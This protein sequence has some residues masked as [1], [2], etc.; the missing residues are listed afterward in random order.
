LVRIASSVANTANISVGI[1]DLG[2]I[3]VSGLSTDRQQAKLIYRQ[4][5]IEVYTPFNTAF[6]REIKQL[7]Y[8]TRLWNKQGK[9]W[10]VDISQ[11]VA[12]LRLIDKFYDIADIADTNEPESLDIPDHIRAKMWELKAMKNVT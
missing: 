12:L 4:D 1:L 6:V 3:I 10:A 8:G 5:V 11:E 2:V 7:P 9:Y